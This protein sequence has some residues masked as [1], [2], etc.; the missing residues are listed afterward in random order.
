MKVC[1]VTVD[2]D[3]L[4]SNLKGFGL[5]KSEYSYHEFERGIETVLEF[6]AVYNVRATFF[7]VAKD[8]QIDKNARLIPKVA[9]RGHEIA[10]HSYS[11]PQG[12]RFIS[13]EQKEYELRESKRIL[14]EIS[15]EEVIGSRSPGWNISDDT[16]PILRST[17]YRYD[18]SVFPT[19]IAWILKLLH[20]WEMR[21][22]DR[23][24]R[25]TLGHLY[26][27]L[28]PTTP[29]RASERRLGLPGSSDF[30]EFP[31]QVAGFF[32]MPF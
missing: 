24:T 2:V 25:T 8:L 15:G 30:I 11:H 22:R 29:Y 3:S 16:L 9:D 21:K 27:A 10:S 7:F 18:S 32:R 6:F 26:Y 4:S 5:K 20:Y 31:V 14:E 12:F 28:S 17:G 1:S 13:S 23:M 19:S